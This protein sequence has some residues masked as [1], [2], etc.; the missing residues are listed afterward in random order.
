[1]KIEDIIMLVKAGYSRAEIEA[2]EAP[3]VEAPK[4]E[5]PKAEAPKVEAPKQETLDDKMASFLNKFLDEQKKLLQ[6][7]ALKNDEMGVEK[8][9]DGIEHLNDY[10]NGR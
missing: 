2:M 6:S 8:E 9:K 1:M 3:K 7:F 10:L 5:A 4:V